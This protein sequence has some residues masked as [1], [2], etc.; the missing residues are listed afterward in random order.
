[1]PETAVAQQ[2]YHIQQ[3]VLSIRPVLQVSLHDVLVGI[4]Q[5]LERKLKD[6]LRAWPPGVTPDAL[7]N[8]NQVVDRFITIAPQSGIKV[9]CVTTLM[10]A[11]TWLIAARSPNKGSVPSVG[12][13]RSRKALSGR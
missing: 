13:S 7:E 9:S 10:L 6:V 5:C 11:G 12:S 8:G 1:M 3:R 4:S 2:W